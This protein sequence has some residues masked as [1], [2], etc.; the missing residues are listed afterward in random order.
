MSEGKPPL[1]DTPRVPQDFGVAPL[2]SFQDTLFG[3]KDKHYLDFIA[4]Q[5]TQLRGTY[6][7]YYVLRSQT[8]RIDGNAPLTDAPG[9]G[10]F[11]RKSKAGGARVDEAIGISA[12]YGE[13][14]VIGPRVDSLR[15]EVTPTWDYADPI[16]VRGIIYRMQRRENPDQRGTIYIRQA[17]YD[18]ARVLS[19]E[20][21]NIQPQPGDVVRLPNLLGSYDKHQPDDSYY[22]VAEVETN[23]TK[24]GSTGFF[25]TYS[26]ALIWQSK[27]DPQRKFPDRIKKP[28][29]PE[30]P[31]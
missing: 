29:Q 23:S 24:F 7:Y 17:T 3:P 16:L 11:D 19:E 2:S 28:D 15:R 22:D 30:P 1:E 6:G 20:E 25:T 10:P 31:T 5:T 26:L 12:L 27:Y 21:W 14:L 8:Q 4:R 18:L 13:P 9:L